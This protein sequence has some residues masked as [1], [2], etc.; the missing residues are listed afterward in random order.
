MNKR[1]NRFFPGQMYSNDISIYPFKDKKTEKKLESDNVKQSGQL[2]EYHKSIGCECSLDWGDKSTDE[3]GHIDYFQRHGYLILR[4]L[5]DTTPL[6]EIPPIERGQY[7]FDDYGNVS[8][9]SEVE[10]QVNGSLSRYNYQKYKEH[11]TKIRLILEELLQEK[12]YNTYYY[13]RFYFLNQELTPHIDRDACEISVSIQI[14]TNR[15]HNY[16]WPFC[17]QSR[18][19]ENHSIFTQNGWG[20]LYMGC[21]RLHWRYPLESRYSNFGKVLNK[22]IRKPD[23]TYHHQVFF[24]YVRANGERSHFANDS[25]K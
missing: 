23:D 20:I 4:N 5:Y 16:E 9:T 24:H 6:Y 8:K 21:E 22:I 15:N 17:I 25:I 12:L 18:T 3:G 10:S 14:S 7:N 11:H 2:L 13:D 1:E 19:G